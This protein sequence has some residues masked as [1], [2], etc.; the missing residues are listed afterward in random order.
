MI[1]QLFIRQS[2]RP[3]ECLGLCLLVG[4]QIMSWNL[5]YTAASELIATPMMSTR[6]S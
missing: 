1:V 6:L 2:T 4:L 3:V 5:I